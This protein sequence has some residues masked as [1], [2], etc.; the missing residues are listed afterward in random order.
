MF[1]F[2]VILEC[3]TVYARNVNVDLRIAEITAFLS[4]ILFFVELPSR[5][6]S[7]DLLQKYARIFIIYYIAAVFYMVARVRT[8][9]LLNYV[10]KFIVFIPLLTLIM[11]VKHQ[12]NELFQFMSKFSGIMSL[13]AITSLFFWTFASQLHLL[14]PTNYIVAMWG[15][16][17]TYPVYYGLYV[18]RQRH[19]FMSFDSIRNQSFFCEAPMFSLC[20][21]MAIAIEFFFPHN[22]CRQKRTHF[23][24]LNRQIPSNF[25]GRAWRIIFLIGAVVTTFSTTGYVLLIMMLVMRFLLSK[26]KTVAVRIMKLLSVGFVV[27][28]G[29]A[30]AIWIFS[31]KA[32]SVSWATRADDFKAGF[33]AWLASPI[34]G[35]G[36]YENS[37]QQYMSS[38]R[39]SNLGF[40]NSIFQVLSQGGLLLFSAYLTG[41][42]GGTIKAL[43]MK[44]YPIV[45]FSIVFT[46]EFIF[47]VFGFNFLMLFVLAFE[48]TIIL[49]TVPK[50]PGKVPLTVRKSKVG[51]GT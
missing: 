27:I 39:G 24:I 9:T 32:S 29:G 44:Q 30:I 20:L 31:M 42:L 26:P 22:G 45:A 41:M 8:D 7:R 6:V 19:I 38:F 35:T 17:F 46:L 33:K 51:D 47:T 14:S 37:A 34:L 1:L 16:N 11:A 36:Y 10:A 40:S 50:T 15:T 2:F 13:L 4:I 28:L 48:Y 18:E 3:N 21:S 23:I 25:N 43:K 12:R 5:A 49:Q